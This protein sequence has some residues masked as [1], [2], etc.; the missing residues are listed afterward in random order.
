MPVTSTPA[1]NTRH[2][3]NPALV[4]AEID[5]K[6]AE[7]ERLRIEW[8]EKALRLLDE[9]ELAKANSSAL[10]WSRVPE[11][12]GYVDPTIDRWIRQELD[13]YA[14]V[15]VIE[16]PRPSGKRFLLVYGDA[17]DSTVSEGTGPFESYAA[18]SDWFLKS[19]R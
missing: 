13:Y 12:P 17:D 19:G 16:M 6:V 4:R 7:L 2:E 5:K 14:L 1:T 18:A 8:K 3:I 9:Y 11:G 10:R 15:R